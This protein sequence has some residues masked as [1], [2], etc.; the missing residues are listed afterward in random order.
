MSLFGQKK[1]IRL[2]GTAVDPLS[3]GLM[4][5]NQAMCY[6]R[7]RRNRY[8]VEVA[9]FCG[10]FDNGSIY[11]VESLRFYLGRN[12][13]DSHTRPKSLPTT[14]TTM[15]DWGKCACVF[16]T[17]KSTL[18]TMNCKKKRISRPGVN[19]GLPQFTKGA[20]TVAL[21]NQLYIWMKHQLQHTTRA[22]CSTMATATPTLVTLTRPTANATATLS[23]RRQGSLD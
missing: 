5:E 12:G 10:A 4:R 9:E 23:Q 7:G 15:R 14:T 1:I 16:Y 8:Q 17:I 21:P 11:S 22:T 19:P 18:N 3:G 20:L 13:R 2:S 6:I